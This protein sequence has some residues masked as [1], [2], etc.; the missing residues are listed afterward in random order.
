MDGT[1]RK[2]Q[3]DEDGTVSEIDLE[4]ATI[5]IYNICIVIV[6]NIIR[7]KR[8]AKYKIMGCRGEDNKKS[9]YKAVQL[10]L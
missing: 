9:I 2:K 7:N 1:G 4:L 6:K 8:Q 10:L 5:S 3:G